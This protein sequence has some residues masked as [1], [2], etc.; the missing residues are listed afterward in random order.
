VRRTHFV[1]PLFVIVA[2]VELIYGAQT[3]QL[4]VYAAQALDLGDEGYGILLTAVGVGGLLS[5]IVNGRLASSRRVTLVVVTAGAVVC[6]T[7]LLYAGVS[8]LTIALAVTVIGSAGMVSCEVVAETA[9]ARIVP[10]ETLGR[11][12]GVFD[13]TMVAAMIAGAVLAP[14]LLEATSLDASFVILGAATLV[15]TLASRIGLRGLDAESGRRADALASRLA[16]VE[17]LTV[18]RG[19]PQLMLERLAAAAQS[20]TLP[21]GVD[22]VVQGAPAHAFYAVAE[23]RVLV[24][25]GETVRARLG[26]GEGFGER[27][28]LDNAPRN[29]TVTTETAATILRIEGELFL[30]ALGAPRTV[31][32]PDRRAV[33]DAPDAP[34]HGSDDTLGDRPTSLAGATL[35]VI[36]AGYPGK[37]RVYERLHDRGARL[38]IVDEPGHWSQGLVREG[39]A[40]EWLEAA[41]TGDPDTDAQAVLEALRGGDV[42]P[43]GIV[44]FWEDSVPVAARVAEAL[45]LPGNPPAAVDAAR[46]KLRTRKTCAELGLPTPRA[47]RVRSLDEL[48]AAALDIGFPAVV[49]PEFGALAV[50]CVRVDELDSLP[51]IYS[52]VSDVVRPE[53]DVIF[54][55]GNDLLL[56]DY[57]DGVEF[58]VDFVLDNGRCAF[59]SVSQNWPTQEPSFQETGLHCPPTH[60]ARQVRELVDFAVQVSVAFGFRRGVLHVEAKY[61]RRGPRI[62]EI[63][64]RM[65]GARIHQI[66]EAV[67]GVDLIEAHAR[68]CL[69]LPLEL[70]PS[71]KPRCTVINVILHAPASGRL[72]ALPFAEITPEGGLGVHVDVEAEVGEDVIGPEGIFATPLAEITLSDRNL[73][74]AR[75]L[76]DEL[77]RDPPKVAP[78]RVLAP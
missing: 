24:H 72:E 26:P 32:D 11:V 9:L 42:R 56:E 17:R 68:S 61:T 33:P 63:N 44:T 60:N 51:R 40:V 20:S 13:A 29:A 34:A 46:S 5:A 62:V 69:D 31:A 77:L 6:V 65:G 10:G 64:A 78:L 48:Y 75:A 4:V 18:T 59:A 16:I 74:R 57:L 21:P 12:V 70:A 23:G 55:A 73:K 27:G 1:L 49:K 58:D 7:Q 66:V 45:G 39:L 15:V 19:V 2:M 28:L 35:A 71:R 8:A 14:V 43:D 53:K 47:E 25:D 76:A 30:E 54:R 52:L 41:V 3:V 67:W 38:V 37:R 36:S 50:G 22:V